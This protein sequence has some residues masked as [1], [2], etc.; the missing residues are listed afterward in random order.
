MVKKA[1]YN[2]L[3]LDI[4][5]VGDNSSREVEYTLS[6]NNTW[7]CRDVEYVVYGMINPSTIQ[8]FV[9][10]SKTRVRPLLFVR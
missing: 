5:G 9:V 4:I 8:S 2:L 3:T 10:P 7:F 1:R 6:T